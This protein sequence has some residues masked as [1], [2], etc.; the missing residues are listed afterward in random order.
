[1]TKSFAM[2]NY[3]HEILD[4]IQGVA[5]MSIDMKG[6]GFNHESLNSKTKFV[7]HVKKT[8]LIMYFHHKH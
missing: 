6:V 5:N 1:M 7:P 3:G 4:E 8:E 2:L